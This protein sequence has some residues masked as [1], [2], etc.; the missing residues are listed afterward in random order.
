[1][2][3]GGD[4]TGVTEVWTELERAMARLTGELALLAPE[5]AE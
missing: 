5:A 4:L 2:A 3:R 1:M